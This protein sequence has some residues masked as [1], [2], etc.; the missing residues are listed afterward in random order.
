MWL[1][2][3]PGLPDLVRVLIA[4]WVGVD[5]RYVRLGRGAMP[6]DAIVVNMVST[7]GSTR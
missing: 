2:K 5:A 3:R 6:T 7:V 1:R 4:R